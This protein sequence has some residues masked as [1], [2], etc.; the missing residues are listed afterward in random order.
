M[1]KLFL[2]LSFLLFLSGLQ[3]QALIFEEQFD[4]GIPDSWEIGPGMPE[5][6]V[7]QWS[8]DG[9]AND[10]DVVG[11]TVMS[12]FWGTRGPIQSPS[13]ANGCAMYNSDIY[14]G[15]GTG[16]GQGM[17][18]GTHSGTLTS[19]SVDC[20]AYPAVSLKM[21]QYAR[22]NANAVS[23]I[24][25]VSNDGGM[26]WTPFVINEA[27]V[28]NGSTTPDDV[29]LVDI[30]EVAGSQA[31][32]KL[33]FTWNGRY[34]FWL[35][36]DVQVIETP[37]NNLALGN[38]IFY[39][40]SSYATPASQIATDTF[41]FSADLSNL[42]RE[43]Q[44]NVILKATVTDNE[45][46]ILYQDS[47]LIDEL[48]VGVKDTFDIESLFV[49]DMLAAGQDYLITYEVY[50]LDNP[51][52]FDPSD[53]SA[54]EE[55]LIT[56]GLFAKDDG[57]GIGGIRTGSGG[58]YKFGNFYQISPASPNVSATNLIFAAGKNSADGPIAGE[59]V[60]LLIYKVNDNVLPDWSNF[61]DAADDDLTLAG[62]QTYTF[63]DDYTN[64]TETTVEMFNLDAEP[65]VPLDAGGRYFAVV[66][67]EGSANNIFAGTDDDINYFQ[68]STVVYSTAWFLGGFGEEEAAV[69]R[70]EITLPVDTDEEL[71]PETSLTVSP[72]PTTDQLNVT[73]DLDAPQEAV[74][75]M[76]DLNG[77][78]L[79][80]R[81][82]QNVQKE[83]FQ[84][85]VSHLPAG[86]YLVRI[87]TTEGISTKKFVVVR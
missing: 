86:T 58:D 47:V 42:G 51:D 16:V 3:A 43:A 13:V 1:K 39:P 37:A 59:Q 68:I 40:P 44:T 45:D 60:T 8:N 4:G 23:T 70:M 28:G 27:V 57:S 35:I 30:S 38:Y 41:G 6:A 83:T 54:S 53:N 73:L 46:N 11:T 63:P 52:D 79:L 21:N 65:L 15:G 55:F 10:G 34:Y 67:Y 77:K 75:I 5:G 31:D 36:D 18:P 25:E 87:G 20:S 17:F 62:F 78:I 12:L 76:A 32:V 14:D 56:E 48:A 2:P 7:W 69:V 26:T 61:N 19:P 66:S 74:V 29:L 22:A 84:Y 82:Y 49:P 80:M 85:N 72:N 33:R 24:L 64:Y 71:L 81:D 9:Q 50:S